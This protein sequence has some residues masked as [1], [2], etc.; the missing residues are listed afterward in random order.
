L[1]KDEILGMSSMPAFAPSYPRGSYR[2]L[3]REYL[4]ATYETD[5][6]TLCAR[7]Y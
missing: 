3:R 6:Q 5:G 2:F 7:L 1:T 4:I